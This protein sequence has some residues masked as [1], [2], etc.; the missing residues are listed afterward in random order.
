M[1][2]HSIDYFLLDLTS[3]FLIFSDLNRKEVTE[4]ESLF[5]F[6]HENVLWDY[7]F[8]AKQRAITQ[9][10]RRSDLLSSINDRLNKIKVESTLFS[11]KNISNKVNRSK[12]RLSRLFL[13]RILFWTAWRFLCDY[14]S[15]KAAPAEEVFFHLHPK[16]III[17]T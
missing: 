2:L 3:G 8:F 12:K 14:Y 1:R 15:R 11:Q 10:K 7:S 17:I 16:L 6:C 5:L 13:T 9:A 4:T